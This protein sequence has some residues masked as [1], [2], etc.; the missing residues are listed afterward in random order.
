MDGSDEAPTVRDGRG[1]FAAGNRGR[2]FGS[3]N[4]VS[5]RSARAILRDFEAHQSDLLPKLRRWFVPQYIQLVAR[6]LPRINEAGLLLTGAGENVLRFSPAL[7]VSMAELEEGVRI[8]RQ[9]LSDPRALRAS[10]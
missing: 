10:A 8:V 2:P 6:L 4:R 3:R 9:V 1:R 7:V 5:K